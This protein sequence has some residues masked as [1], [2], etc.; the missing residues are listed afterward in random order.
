MEYA[1]IL[2][3]LAA[4]GKLWYRFFSRNAPFNFA[5]APHVEHTRA[6]ENRIFRYPIHSYCGIRESSMNGQAREDGKNYHTPAFVR[7]G[8]PVAL[9]QQSSS[10]SPK[11]PCRTFT[12]KLL[13][14]SSVRI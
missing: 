4:G 2:F 13:F 12:E 7:M 14:G 8:P 5:G 9:P 6:C 11:E 10:S 1:D 3:Y